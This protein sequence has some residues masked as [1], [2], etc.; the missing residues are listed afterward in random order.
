VH[1]AELRAPR[2]QVAK[3]AR[4]CSAALEFQ[5]S[6]DLRPIGLA[7]EER[8]DSG[9]GSL[10]SNSKKRSQKWGASG[11]AL[12]TLLK[13]EA[14]G[15]AFDEMEAQRVRAPELFENRLQKAL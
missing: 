6:R 13:V 8:E 9:R 15:R 7:S 12:V 5:T 3:L 14:K 10:A 4:R 11:Q 1:P 2:R